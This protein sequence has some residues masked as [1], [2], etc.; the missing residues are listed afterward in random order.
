M[1]LKY[2]SFAFLTTIFLINQ[3]PY[4]V[5]SQNSP[6]GVLYNCLLD[7]TSLR[8]FGCLCFPYLRP[9]ASHKME[10]RS[11]ICCFLGYSAKHKGFL[12]LDMASSR[13]YASRHVVFDETQFP[14][15]T[16]FLSSQPVSSSNYSSTLLDY[17][18]LSIPTQSSRN[19]NNPQPNFS[20]PVTIPTDSVPIS[21]LFDFPLV[22][23]NPPSSPTLP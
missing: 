7:Y 4:T 9:Y 13:I 19:L 14:F 6:Y 5:L 3:L 11:I 23:S 10:N 16:K 8:S 2:W 15:L 12:Y 22:P 20:S 17:G 18:I 21:T 1:P